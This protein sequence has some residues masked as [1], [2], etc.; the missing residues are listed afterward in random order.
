MLTDS[1]TYMEEN[2]ICDMGETIRA[3]DEA[4]TPEEQARIITEGLEERQRGASFFK[5]SW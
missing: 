4:F 3:F 1:A 2:G 5:E